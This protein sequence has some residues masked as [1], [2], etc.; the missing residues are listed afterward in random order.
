[1]LVRHHC[2]RLQCRLGQPY[3][4]PVQHEPLH[5]RG[6]VRVRVE[7]PS[8][9]RPAQFETATL[10]GVPGGKRREL[11]AD[12]LG[13]LLQYLREGELGHRLVHDHEDRLQRRP[14]I[15][16]RSGRHLLCRLGLGSRH[17]LQFRLGGRRHIEQHRLG[18]F[19]LG[20]RR[21]LQFGP[22][23]RKDID[24]TNQAIPRFAR[25]S[26]RRR[27]LELPTPSATHR[28]NWTEWG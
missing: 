10:G 4:L 8:A 9:G 11:G 13:G 1:M 12:P 17:R 14:K 5:V 28:T 2:E 23:V 27:V 25:V 22:S 6:L 21:R 26:A 15:H 24:P 20:F 19:G 3:R 18:R 16:D 7:A